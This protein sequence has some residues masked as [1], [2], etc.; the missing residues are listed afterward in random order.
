MASWGAD[1]AVAAEIAE[2]ALNLVLDRYLDVLRAQNQVR[3]Q[4][5]VPVCHR[6]QVDR[7][8]RSP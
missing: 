3:F 8:H 5:P 7:F 2:S 1:Y 6:Y 4:G